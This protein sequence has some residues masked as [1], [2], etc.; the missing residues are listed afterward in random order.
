M[1]IILEKGTDYKLII[2]KKPD[3]YLMKLSKKDKKILQLI[4]DGIEE[5]KNNPYNSSI[6]KGQF[7]GKRRKRK[8]LYRIIFKINKN[9]NPPEIHILDIAKRGSIYKH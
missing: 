9:T 1:L 2:A 4:I 7:K 6:L 5:I 3:Q 8:G